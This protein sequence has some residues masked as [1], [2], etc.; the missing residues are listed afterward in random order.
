MTASVF[1]IRGHAGSLAA[2]YYA[3]VGAPHSAGDVLIAPALAEE[4]NRCRAMVAMQARRLA[5]HGIGTLVLDPFG[6]GDSAGEFEDGTWSSWR[7]DLRKGIEWLRREGNGCRTLWGVRLGA[8][9]AAQL[10]ADD[11]GID[12]LLLWQ[13][14]IDARAFYTQ[15]LRIRVAA[16]LEKSDGIKSTEELRRRSSAGDAIEVS[17]Y[18]IGPGLGQELDQQRFPLATALG[19]VQLLWC[20]VLPSDDSSIPRA[21]AKCAEEYRAAGIRIEM[22]RAIGPA[23]WQMHERV[24]APDLI[25]ITSRLLLAHPEPAA[26][27]A[28]QGSAHHAVPEPARAP[29]SGD[30]EYGLT[31]PCMGETLAGIVHPGNARR[32]VVIV[33]AGGPQYRAGAHRQFVSLARKLAALGYP[34]LRFDLRGMGDSSG[35]YRG[36]EHSEPDIRSAID[37]LIAREK[38]VQ[39]IVLFGECESASGIL[40]NAYRDPR[41]KGIALVNPWVRTEGGRAEVIIKHYYARRLLSA[42]FWR[43]VRAGQFDVLASLRD[44]TTTVRAYVRGRRVRKLSGAGPADEDLT[45]LPLPVKTAL[46][47][48]RFRGPVMLLMSGH[49]YI[50]REFDEVVKSSTAWAGL[51][52]DRR[53]SRHDLPEADHTFSRELWKRQASDRICQWIRSW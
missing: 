3:P 32:G 4:M 39:E 27:V 40:F 24:L 49:D 6:T 12:R 1:Y 25:S 37:A 35:E 28:S 26:A 52:T 31:F 11:Q 22:E 33:V 47:L 36:F 17:G 19:S 8:I 20:E 2:V 34:V 21:N 44:L 5:E 48:R 9:M 42:D 50:A 10:A 23:F 13:P 51:L 53:V 41:V 46:G 29:E 38:G 15:F 30:A 14:V 16:D 43:K 45:M 18:Q 7:D